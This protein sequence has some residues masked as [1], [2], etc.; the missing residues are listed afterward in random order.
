MAADM[1][2]HGGDIY[3]YIEETG[4]LPLDYSANINPLGLTKE[5]KKAYISAL[6][7]LGS[8]P[9]V[10]LRGLCR[11]TARYE[12]C[13]EEYLLFGNGA[14]EL[15]Y[16]ICCALR[17]GKALLPAPA[18]SEYGQALQSTG[19]ELEYFMLKPGNNFA[20]TEAVLPRISGKDIVF[21]CNPNNPTGGIIEP[22]LLYD[23]AGKCREEGCILVIDECF[24]DF[25]SGKESYSFKKY[26]PQFEQVIILR[27]FTK[28]FA[29]P[30]LRLGYLMCSSRDIIAKLKAA[31][32]AWSV[33]VP[34]QAAG[35]AALMDSE[36]LDKTVKLITKERSYLV[37]ALKRLGFTV[38]PGEANF[39]LFRTQD[40]NLYQKLYR[41]GILIRRC[42]N[43]MGLDSSYYR[44]AVKLRKDNRR[45]VAA[46]REV[47]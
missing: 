8:Y 38:F 17:P 14:A 24:M 1:N 5:V 27:A 34:A 13:R 40:R 18:F 7:G 46:I 45:L 39:I 43:F 29:M 21:L 47:V 6:S 20:L 9:D 44:I 23:I 35:E 37:K 26:L 3:G 41:K 31:G 15:I 42:E 11:E 30:G 2:A 19:C 10:S 25:V 32:Q 4:K 28:I 33:S 36:Y 12:A 22:G 16:R